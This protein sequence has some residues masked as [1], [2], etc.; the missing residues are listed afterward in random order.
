MAKIHV[1]NPRRYRVQIS[2][3][4]ALWGRY[5]GN[6]E[7]AKSLGAEIDYAKEFETW[8]AKQNEQVTAALQLLQTQQQSEAASLKSGGAANGIC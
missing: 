6:L 1:K 7:L 3:S 4:K 2:I 5:K 8:F